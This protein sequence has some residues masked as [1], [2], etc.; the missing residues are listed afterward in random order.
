MAREV[1]VGR[2]VV[3]VGR[4]V[5]VGGQGG[6]G[7]P[8]CGDGWPERSWKAGWSHWVARNVVVGMIVL[9]GGQGGRGGPDS[10]S[11]WPGSWLWG[12]KPP[13]RGPGEVAAG[14]NRRWGFQGDEGRWWW[15][16]SVGGRR[17]E[18]VVEKR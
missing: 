18:L 12:S 13:C 10:C 17:R 8:E 16:K 6:G 15:A 5:V 9:E 4:I 14:E 11:R 2:I 1:V 7:G 3:V